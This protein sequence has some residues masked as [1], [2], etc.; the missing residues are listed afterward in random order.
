MRKNIDSLFLAIGIILSLVWM[1]RLFDQ[2]NEFTDLHLKLQEE[3]ICPGT[4]AEW[5]DEKTVQ[6][7]NGKK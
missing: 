2:S 3:Y 1:V 4:H 7:I 6:C 5:V